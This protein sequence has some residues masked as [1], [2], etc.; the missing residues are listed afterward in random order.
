MILLG[1]AF[2][3]RVTQTALGDW[4]YEKAFA[5]AEEIP[6][7]DDMAAAEKALRYDPGNVQAM[8]FLGDSHRKYA[9]LQKEPMDRE[10]EES[11][12]LEAYLKALRANPLDLSVEAR[13]AR[14]PGQ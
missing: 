8:V 3:A 7:S 12:A 11:M 9:A 5:H 6:L 14:M 2:G 4:P 13:V 10:R 1:V